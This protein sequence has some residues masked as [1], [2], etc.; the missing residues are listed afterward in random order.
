SQIDVHFDGVTDSDSRSD[1]CRTPLSAVVDKQTSSLAVTPG[2]PPLTLTD[3]LTNAQVQ[4]Y[5]ITITNNNPVLATNVEVTDDFSPG[6]S[7]NSNFLITW[8]VGSSRTA[9]V[10]PVLGDNPARWCCWDLAAGDTLRIE[11]VADISNDVGSGNY[12]N[13]ITCTSTNIRCEEF[14]KLLTD[15]DDVS[16][17]WLGPNHVFVRSF[18]AL[19]GDH[20]DV[21]LRWETDAE[22]RTL[23]FFL[24]R[25]ER[26]RGE[27]EMVRDELLPALVGTPQG[28]TYR[29]VDGDAAVG[30]PLSYLLV[31]LE[32]DG[33]ERIY[34][35]FEVT[36]DDEAEELPQAVGAM[37]GDGWSATPEPLRVA[38]KASSEPRATIMLTAGDGLRIAVREP[39]LYRVEALR[40]GAALGKSRRDTVQLIRSGHLRLT[41]EDREVPWMAAEGRGKATGIL[42][43]GEGTD[44]IFTRDRIYLLTEGRGTT[45]AKVAGAPHGGD[46]PGA[47]FHD[48]LRFSE[49]H[50]PLVL[51]RL[52]PDEDLW[53]W[54]YVI[55]GQESKSFELQ[56]PGVGGGSPRFRAPQLTVHLKGAVE[57]GLGEHRVRALWNGVALGERTFSDFESRAFTFAL[58]PGLILEG[59]NTV[60]LVAMP[61]PDVVY[62]IFYV[63]RIELWYERSY[64]S[65]QP[66]LFA[67]NEGH[68]LL[69]LSGFA[70]TDLQLFEV[71]DPW[72][73]K[74]VQGARV[75]QDPWGDTQVSFTPAAVD[76]RYLAVTSSGIR[77]PAS[78]RV[79]HFSDLA[80]P[81]NWADYLIIT[82][83]E[84][85]A[86]AE[87]LADHRQSQGLR[88]MV[89]DVDDVMD[90][91]NGGQFDPRALHEFLVHARTQWWRSPRY[92]AL[93]GEGTFDYKDAW[94]LGTNV[95]PPLMVAAGWG[96]YASDNRLADLVGEDGVPEVAIG[97]IPVET[98]EQ[99]DAYVD[100]VIAY[101]LDQDE[102]WTGQVLLAADDPDVTGQYTIDSDS[103][104]ALVPRTLVKNRI[105]LGWMGI[106]E[107]SAALIQTLNAGVPLVTYIGHAGLTQLAHEGLLR[108]SDVPGLT[109]A[110]RTPVVAVLGCYLGN[111]SL[112]GY[113]TLGE[114]LVL[115][116]EGGAAAVW[117]PAGIS[118]NPHRL[119]LGEAFLEAV[120]EQGV[121]VVGDA[122]LYAQGAA[123]AR[124]A[125]NRR[126]ILDSQVL[127]GD[128]ALRLKTKQAVP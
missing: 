21:V 84:L 126:D 119:V 31:E 49:D 26:D 81:T 42:F 88:A 78:L 32:S 11:F 99:L 75:E 90:E 24:L 35:P 2:S 62:S 67:R 122:V 66:W 73:P 123:A 95:L 69:T 48:T 8:G 27:W 41:L 52:D 105:Y 113:P 3:L 96:L 4:N 36:A 34:G 60:E 97:R 63:E 108:S 64:R 50:V 47:S 112:P 110:H 124:L 94:G 54:D 109:N 92:V 91:W 44:S 51:G 39:G 38:Q 87:R 30:E 55:A 100:K 45:M 17:L 10:D 89:V 58:D 18:E 101:E 79:D 127:L 125:G 85:R 114:D 72:D 74:H 25:L 116:A 86:T 65:S 20:G 53:F 111:F 106:A 102:S 98:A 80:S 43:Y 1:V 56:V 103:L 107:A 120:F 29:V 68:D 12:Q 76:A 7:F 82:T 6:F 15:Q 118:Y 61:D 83:A 19:I 13:G 115:H 28:G 104:A 59:Q 117:S 128:P 46:E 9:V 71:S 37:A 33:N 14:D 40:I 121:D 16:V 57:T 93:V 22:T 70:E 23:G 77:E 5:V